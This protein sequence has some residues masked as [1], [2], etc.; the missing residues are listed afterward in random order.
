MIIFGIS[1]F[2][3]MLEIIL[4]LGGV[5]YLSLQEFRNRLSLERSVPGQFRIL[6]LGESTTA[7]GG[8]DSYPSLLEEILNQRLSP[9]KFNVIN[10]GLP[11]LDTNV[12][13]AELEYNLN[14][15][16]PRIV[17]AM[18][19]I[20]DDS[21]SLSRGDTI[22]RM[23]CF[24]KSLRVYKTAV[25]LSARFRSKNTL[26]NAYFEQGLAFLELRHYPEAER[27][28]SQAARL[29]PREPLAYIFL[30][31]CYYEQGL[32]VEAQRLIDNAQRLAGK[33]PQAYVDLGWYYYD[34]G[35]FA[36]A[37]E[38]LKKAIE[39]N[40]RNPDYYYDLAQ[41]CQSQGRYPEAEAF[42]K[43][44]IELKAG[45]DYNIYVDFGLHYF[46][47]GLFPEAENMLKR[48]LR[49]NADDPRV[50][51]YL[52]FV[53]E[54]QGKKDDAV[55]YFNRMKSVLDPAHKTTSRNYAQLR[56]VVLRRG[57]KLVCAQYPLRNVETLERMFTDP[58]GIVLVDN[59]GIFKE[60]LKDGRYQD[61]F[62]DKFAGD[63]GHCTRKGN[64]LLANNIAQAII[65]E[66][67]NDKQ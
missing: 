42:F 53:K 54:S 30:S 19:G 44:T 26:K 12:I 29:A 41:F 35:F 21:I 40:P 18:M 61:Y 17:I 49:M 10:R 56:D 22:S 63:F 23:K 2:V 64:M 57:I 15:Y 32:N 3:V 45:N 60:A 24:V 1:L 66:Y 8:R 16:N 55:S 43:K 67:F 31:R 58:E 47:R 4:R 33:Y 25:L 7:L 48:S 27:M 9:K 59:E 36:R 14:K 52:G 50:Y 20:N 6:C 28:F 62:V 46:E 39:F 51:W 13:L 34:V 11:S 38:M 37:E 65:K 5:A